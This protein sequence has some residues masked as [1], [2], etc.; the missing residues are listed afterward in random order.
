MKK[1]EKKVV[2]IGDIL[3][4]TKL[5][6]F[7]EICIEFSGTWPRQKIE[8]FSMHGVVAPMK[9]G[10]AKGS[11]GQIY[12]EIRESV[13]EKTLE[14]SKGWDEVSVLGLLRLWDDYHLNDLQAGCEH[15]RALGWKSYD[16]HP[17]EPCP[18]CGYKYGSSWLTKEVP[19]KVIEVVRNMPEASRIPAWV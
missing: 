6:V 11:C 2:Y 19:S 17:S 12:D 1:E 13:F 14:Y 5:P 4:G 10:D 18:T 8:R 3:D 15:Q 16:E 7:I 9:N